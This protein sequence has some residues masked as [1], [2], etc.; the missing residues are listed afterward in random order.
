MTLGQ[1][2][3]QATYEEMKLWAAHFELNH[4]EAI[5]AERKARRRR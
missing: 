3:E 4:D 2:Q 1:L 5:A